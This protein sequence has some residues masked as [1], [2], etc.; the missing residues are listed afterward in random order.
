MAAQD[1]APL[2][3]P[4]SDKA[5]M[6]SQAWSEWLRKLSGASERAASGYLKLQGGF[7]LQWGIT[8][9]INSASSTDVTFPLAFPNTCLQVVVSVRNNSGTATSATGMPGTGAYTSSQ[10]TLW[11]RTSVNQVFNWLAVGY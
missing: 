3:A 8:D 2:L 10:F 5:G 1:A 6:V 7:I 4:I 9:T 11:N